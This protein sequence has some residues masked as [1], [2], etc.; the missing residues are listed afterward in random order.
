LWLP[1]ALV[2]EFSSW[3]DDNGKD[4]STKLIVL[5]DHKPAMAFDFGLA[6]PS[7]SDESYRG[8]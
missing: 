2:L 6:K 5:L 8:F 7:S 3:S 4:K 1:P